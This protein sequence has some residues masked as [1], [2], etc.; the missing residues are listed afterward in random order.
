MT[1]AKSSS[2]SSAKSGVEKLIE[3]SGVTAEAVQ[4]KTVPAQS[5]TKVE[6]K[7]DDDGRLQ[8]RVSD[9]EDV[10]FQ[11]AKVHKDV[12]ELLEEG[13]VAHVALVDGEIVI[14]G[15]EPG[16]VKK[17]V[18]GAK[19]KLKKNKK[20][21]IGGGIA[22]LAIALGVTVQKSRAIT[23]GDEQVEPA[24]DEPTDS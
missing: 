13:V 14:T 4:E 22:I 3:E 24:A 9:D 2:A 10:T 18:S 23:E 11:G 7:R 21:I 17:L 12:T 5:A 19:G 15:V 1:N 20:A 8:I 6:A 16:K